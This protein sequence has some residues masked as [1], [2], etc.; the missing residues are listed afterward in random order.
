VWCELSEAER[1]AFSNPGDLPKITASDIDFDGS[2]E[3]HLLTE[4]LSVLLRPGDGLTVSELTLLP[5]GRAP[6]PLG[7]SLTRRREAYHA[8]ISD[9]A[10]AGD[11]A[12]TIHSDLPA[13]E[14]G[15]ASKLVLDNYRRVSFRSL[16]LPAE[17]GRDKWFSSSAD[18]IA[19]LELQGKPTVERHGD[20]L[21]MAGTLVSGKARLEKRLTIDLH[22]PLMVFRSTSSGLEGFTQACEICLNLL[23]GSESDRFV[24]LGR[25]RPISTGSRGTGVCRDLIVEDGWRGVRVRLTSTSFIEAAHMPLDSINRSERGYERVHQGMALLLAPG[26]STGNVLELRIEFEDLK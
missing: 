25:S 6:V 12:R 8:G 19:P 22:R 15:L 24:G 10:A 17:A 26:A 14:K 1:I 5:P 23:T 18:V 9:D 2:L 16:L 3:V 20:M 7:H 21:V 11:S 4:S 13:T